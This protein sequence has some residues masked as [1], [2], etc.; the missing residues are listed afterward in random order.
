[1]FVIL[2]HAPPSH[3]D[4]VFDTFVD[5]FT[6]KSLFPL[7]YMKWLSLYNLLYVWS[8]SKIHGLARSFSP[9]LTFH[10][11]LKSAQVVLE[12]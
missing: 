5:S 3:T 9:I 8:L 2:Q 12:Y 6:S 1:M 4:V 10:N 11:V 7:F